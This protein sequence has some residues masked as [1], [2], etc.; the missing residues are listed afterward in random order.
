MHSCRHIEYE[1]AKHGC[2]SVVAFVKPFVVCINNLSEPSC[3]HTDSDGFTKHVWK[4]E[5]PVP[6][7]FEAVTV[8]AKRYTDL[9]ELQIK[10]SECDPQQESWTGTFGGESLTLTKPNWETMSADVAHALTLVTESQK[11]TSRLQALHGNLVQKL[12]QKCS[13]KPNDHVFPKRQKHDYVQTC[14][15]C[16]YTAHLVHALD[17]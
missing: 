16:G 12:Q 1:N 17:F 2:V 15:R 8:Q 13:M 10:Y 5:Q 14:S 11:E 6:L 7:Q 3:A 4:P 9:A